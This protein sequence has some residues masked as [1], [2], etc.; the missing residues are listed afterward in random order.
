M[1]QGPNI[2]LLSLLGVIRSEFIRNSSPFAILVQ[3]VGLAGDD[4][5][6]AGRSASPQ[7][8]GTCEYMDKPTR[9]T[10]TAKAWT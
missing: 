1:P 8:V 10:D 9:S 7:R 3:V 5:D 2:A 4:M 6:F